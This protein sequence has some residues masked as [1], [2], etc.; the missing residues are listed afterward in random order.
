[1][2]IEEPLEQLAGTFTLG[3]TFCYFL[4][5]A[6]VQDE[7]AAGRSPVFGLQDAR[8]ESVD[9]RQENTSI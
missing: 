6:A 8:V 1:M 7:V 9:C 2:L 3:D 4:L 5:S